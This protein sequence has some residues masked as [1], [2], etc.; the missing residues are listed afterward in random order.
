MRIESSDKKWEFIHLVIVHM[1]MAPMAHSHHSPSHRPVD[2][3]P[4]TT[5]RIHAAQASTLSIAQSLVLEKELGG[6]TETNIQFGTQLGGWLLNSGLTLALRDDTSLEQD[7]ALVGPID[8]S[9]GYL[10]ENAQKGWFYVGGGHSSPRWLYHNGDEIDSGLWMSRM[11]LSYGRQF[12]NKGYWLST[13]LGYGHRSGASDIALSGGGFHVFDNQAVLSVAPILSHQIWI[14]SGRSRTRVGIEGRYSMRVSKNL[15]L[16]MSL[17]S[18]N[19]SKLIR[20]A[21]GLIYAFGGPV[22]ALRVEED[23]F[24]CDCEEHI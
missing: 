20:G 15:R 1:L 5:N 11:I 4:G 23:H 16:A 24:E 21:F 19:G 9:L 2:G 22:P 10:F 13:S 6:S 8:L 14:D 7:A 12:S 3:A 17:S 18:T